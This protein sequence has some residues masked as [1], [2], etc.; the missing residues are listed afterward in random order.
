[1][2]V[3]TKQQLEYS[4]ATSWEMQAVVVA[5]VISGIQTLQGS[6]FC[7]KV[8]RVILAIS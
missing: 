1:L 3:S 6:I 5:K 2:A 4:L 8:A 7:P